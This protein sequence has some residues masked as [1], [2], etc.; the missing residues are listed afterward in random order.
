MRRISRIVQ[1]L[2]DAILVIPS[3]VLISTDIGPDK[4]MA[5]YILAGI[6]AVILVLTII[7]LVLNAFRVKRKGFFYGN[8]IFQLL[9]SFLLLGLIMPL[10]AI[11][12]GFNIAV[13]VSLVEG[14]TPEELLKH[15]PKPITKKYRITVGIGVLV[16]FASIFI[17]WLVSIN[18]PLFGFYIGLVDLFAVSNIVGDSLVMMVIG[19][20]TLIGT[21]IL[22][23]TGVLGLLKR[24]C[25]CISAILAFVI[26]IGWIVTLTAVV[27]TGPFILLLGAIIVLVAHL[28]DK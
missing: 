3:I 23:I 16:M 12:L 15:P 5:N 8:A 4:E 26:A 19:L 18:A 28:I 27:G 21:P 25:A 9:I 11:L 13:I 24:V 2:R 10:G 14:K 7:N 20:L 1:T 17:S 22:L 6:C